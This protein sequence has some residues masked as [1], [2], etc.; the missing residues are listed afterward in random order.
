MANFLQ[1]IKDKFPI[2]KA[3]R[4]DGKDWVNTVHIM[5]IL[6]L[7]KAKAIV[8]YKIISPFKQFSVLFNILN[9]LYL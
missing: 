8:Q 9:A 1:P 4:K 7:N 6:L 5:L 2:H 3:I